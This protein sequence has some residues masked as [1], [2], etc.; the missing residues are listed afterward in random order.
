VVGCRGN[1]QMPCYHG[2]DL[3]ADPSARTMAE[4]RAINSPPT[5][6]DLQHDDWK[7]DGHADQRRLTP[8]D[9]HRWFRCR[10]RPAG[11]HVGQRQLSKVGVSALTALGWR[12]ASTDA[13]R[14]FPVGRPVTACAVCLSTASGRNPPESAP[15]G[16]R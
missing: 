3:V 7:D 4:D 5:G 1:D 2:A 8:T 15:I 16:D 11:G 13:R 14:T 9:R 10:D 6:V 12:R